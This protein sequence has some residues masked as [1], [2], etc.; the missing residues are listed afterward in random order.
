ML[1]L[2][3]ALERGALQARG[4]GVSRLR[5]A[6]RHGGVQGRRVVVVHCRH[7]RWAD[8][9]VFRCRVAHVLIRRRQADPVDERVRSRP[10]RVWRV[11]EAARRRV[12]SRHSSVLGLG[13][14]R[15]RR[16][17]QA[18][19]AGIPRQGIALGHGR[20]QCR[21]VIVIHR[22]DRRRHG[23]VLRRLVARLL[24]RHR[25]AD[26]V[27][28]R[29][30]S[31]PVR[32]RRVR[33][34]PVVRRIPGH[35]PVSRLGRLRHRRARNSPWDRRRVTRASI[36]GRH[37]RVHRRRV[38]VVHRRHRRQHREVLRR[39]GAGPVIRRREAHDVAE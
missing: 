36:A 39:D 27:G 25:Q 34:R 31:V 7:R 4:A 5:I 11:G 12:P 20:V 32:D 14:L 35:G 1:G 13:R 21:G 24:V 6:P 17:L 33:E 29:I 22:G 26:A 37:R 2:G 23:D 15:E 10:V 16:T 9:D 19:R 38:V 3:R 8:R 30:R 18:R 28:E